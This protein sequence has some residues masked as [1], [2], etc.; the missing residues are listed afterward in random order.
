MKREVSKGKM[1]KYPNILLYMVF[2]GKLDFAALVKRR[3]CNQCQQIKQH[4]F[5]KSGLH[6]PESLFK[7]KTCYLLSPENI[8][9]TEHKTSIVPSLKHK[10]LKG[11]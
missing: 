3:C 1:E 10:R 4:K 9:K 11:Q 7:F 6:S 2:D 5:E 8:M